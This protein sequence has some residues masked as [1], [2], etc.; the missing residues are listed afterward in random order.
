MLGHAAMVN[1]IGAVPDTGD[2]LQ[3]PDVH[4][5][6]YRKEPRPG[7]KVGHITVRADD[8]DTVRERVTQLRTLDGA[9]P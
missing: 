9:R 4:L 2:A 3:Y 7:R 6:L 5:H 8:P 1:F